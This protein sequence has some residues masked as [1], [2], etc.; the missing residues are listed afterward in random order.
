[1]QQ[2]ATTEQIFIEH[3][4]SFSTQLIK[5]VHDLIE[6]GGQI[7]SSYIKVGLH[8]ASALGAIIKEGNVVATCC[9]KNP[10]NSYRDNVFTSAGVKDIK[11]T[12]S[13][14]L[15]Y[16]VTH[17]A[18]EGQRFCQKLITEML[19]LFNKKFIFATTRKPA[20]VHILKKF[21]FKPVGRTYKND[22]IL[23]VHIP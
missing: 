2:S 4:S 18:H 16:I 7:P 15:G 21:G 3:P 9:L 10:T 1:M 22:L 14:E 19:P 12:F 20:M 23:L 6:D 17:N 5:Q 11:D 8:R 13:Q